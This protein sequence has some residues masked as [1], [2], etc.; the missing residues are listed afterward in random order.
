M[1][2]RYKNQIG[3]RVPPALLT[4]LEKE[5]INNYRSVN[6]ETIFILQRHFDE[7]DRGR[8]SQTQQVVQK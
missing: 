2:S 6:K 4:R 5:A 3:L 7:L 1:S 8:Q